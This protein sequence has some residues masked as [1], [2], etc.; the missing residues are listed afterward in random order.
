MGWTLIVR[1]LE[2]KYLVA[3]WASVGAAQLISYRSERVSD[4]SLDPLAG[5]HRSIV[6]MSLFECFVLNFLTC[7][8]TK[9]DT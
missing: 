7:T 5:G 4:A 2:L 9:I 8:M 3:I 6:I 1:K